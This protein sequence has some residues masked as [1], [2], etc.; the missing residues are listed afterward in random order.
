MED[1]VFGAVPTVT[2]YSGVNTTTITTP[3][4]QQMISHPSNTTRRD[5]SKDVDNFVRS[6]LHASTVHARALTSKKQ[7]ESEAQQVYQNLWAFQNSTSTS[8]GVC[9]CDNTIHFDYQNSQAVFNQQNY[10]VFTQRLQHLYALNFRVILPSLTDQTAYEVELARYVTSLASSNKDLT[11]VLDRLLDSLSHKGFLPSAHTINFLRELVTFTAITI[12]RSRS[13]DSE[14]EETPQSPS[15]SLISFNNPSSSSPSQ[16][17]IPG[18]ITASSLI[19]FPSVPTST[20]SSPPASTSSSSAKTTTLPLA[21]LLLYKILQTPSP[22]WST[23]LI[24]PLPHDLISHPFLS[25]L[26]PSADSPPASSYK[27]SESDYSS[28]LV[29]IP[30]SQLLCSQ[31]PPDYDFLKLNILTPLQRAINLCATSG[32]VPNASNSLPGTVTNASATASVPWVDTLILISKIITMIANVY[33]FEGNVLKCLAILTRTSWPSKLYTVPFLPLLAW[34]VLNPAGL[35]LG[36]AEIYN[37]TGTQ[38]NIQGYAGTNEKGKAE[39]RNRILSFMVQAASLIQSQTF[40]MLT[41][42]QKKTGFYPIFKCLS[43]IGACSKEFKLF[44]EELSF[45]AYIAAWGTNNPATQTARREAERE[46]VRI[47]LRSSDCIN[48]VIATLGNHLPAI[49]DIPFTL[50]SID[51]IIQRL[52]ENKLEWEISRA[53]LSWLGYFI[54]HRHPPT[55]SAEEDVDIWLN[56]WLGGRIGKQTGRVEFPQQAAVNGINVACKLVE[57]LI[58]KPDS[59]KDVPGWRWKLLLMLLGSKMIVG[60]EWLWKTLFKSKLCSDITRRE[61]EFVNEFI[62]R[63]IFDVSDYNDRHD[64]NLGAIEV[65]IVQVLFLLENLKTKKLKALASRSNNNNNNNDNNDTNEER[66][67]SSYLSGVDLKKYNVWNK[68]KFLVVSMNES[69]KGRPFPRDVV[70]QKILPIMFEL[71]MEEGEKYWREAYD[72]VT[73]YLFGSPTQQSSLSQRYGQMEGIKRDL[74]RLQREMRNL[75]FSSLSKSALTHDL[76]LAVK[77]WTKVLSHTSSDS[78]PTNA[79]GGTGIAGE[80]GRFSEDVLNEV[81]HGVW[82][83]Q[84]LNKDEVAPFQN[85]INIL[86]QQGVGDSR[87]INKAVNDGHVWISYVGT[88]INIQFGREAGNDGEIVKVCQ[89]L[90]MKTKDPILA[91]LFWDQFWQ[92]YFKTMTPNSSSGFGGNVMKN[93]LYEHFQRMAQRF[94]S[95]QKSQLTNVAPQ[96]MFY[97]LYYAF[98]TFSP[99]VI[100]GRGRIFDSMDL[101]QAFVAVCP[102]LWVPGAIN[103]ENANNNDSESFGTFHQRVDEETEERERREGRDEVLAMLIESISEPLPLPNYTQIKMGGT[104]LNQYE[105]LLQQNI[106]FLMNTNNS[107]MILPLLDKV[108][109]GLYQLASGKRMLVSSDEQFLSLARQLYKNAFTPFSVSVDCVSRGHRGMAAGGRQCFKPAVISGTK[110]GI[111]TGFPGIENE[112][113][114]NREAYNAQYLQIFTVGDNSEGG[115]TGLGGELA[116]WVVLLTDITYWLIRNR[117]NDIETGKKLFFFLFALILD[118]DNLTDVNAEGGFW[119]GVINCLLILGQTFVKNDPTAQYPILNTILSRL[120]SARRQSGDDPEASQANQKRIA[121]AAESWQVL[122]PIYE[123]FNPNIVFEAGDTNEASQQ[124]LMNEY[125]EMINII[126]F[127]STDLPASELSWLSERFNVDLFFARIQQLCEQNQ[128]EATTMQAMM[129]LTSQLLLHPALSVTLGTNFLL[130]LLTL[131]FPQWLGTVVSVLVHVTDTQKTPSRS[132]WEK[133]FF[134]KLTNLSQKNQG[135]LSFAM[136]W[137]KVLTSAV[138]VLRPGFFLLYLDIIKTQIL[139]SSEFMTELIQQAWGNSS[140]AQE[141]DE[142]EKPIRESPGTNLWSQGVELLLS[143]IVLSLLPSTVLPMNTVLEPVIVTLCD[144]VHQYPLLIDKIWYFYIQYLSK[145]FKKV[146]ND[147]NDNNQNLG[148]T[149]EQ[150]TALVNMISG[151]PWKHATFHI[152]DKSTTRELSKQMLMNRD[153]VYRIFD[154]LNWNSF[155]NLLND[156][157]SWVVPETNAFNKSEWSDTALYYL[158]LLFVVHIFK[159]HAPQGFFSSSYTSSSSSV[160]G[161]SAPTSSTSVT[162]LTTIDTMIDWSKIETGCFETIFDGTALIEPL[163]VRSFVLNQHSDPTLSLL[164]NAYMLRDV[165]LQINHPRAAVACVREVKSLCYFTL[166]QPLAPN[167]TVELG[168]FIPF[169][170]HLKLLTTIVIPISHQY[171]QHTAVASQFIMF[172]LS[173]LEDEWSKPVKIPVQIPWIT[174][175]PNVQV[176]PLPQ[177]LEDTTNQSLAAKIF[178]TSTK[179]DL[180]PFL[181][182][183]NGIVTQ[184]CASSS[185]EV[186]VEVLNISSSIIKEQSTLWMIYEVTLHSYFTQSTRTNPLSEATAAIAKPLNLSFGDTFELCIQLHTPLTFFVFIEQFKKSFDDLNNNWNRFLEFTVDYIIRFEPRGNREFE[187]LLLWFVVLDLI[188]D[189]RTRVNSEQIKTVVEKVLKYWQGFWKGEGK[190]GRVEKL[191]KVVTGVMSEWWSK[192]RI[193]VARNS[194]GRMQLGARSC[195]LQLGKIWRKKGGNSEVFVGIGGG[196]EDL[197]KEKEK[198]TGEEFKEFFEGLE[199]LESALM[200]VDDFKRTVL[201]RLVPIAPYLIRLTGGEAPGNSTS[202]NLDKKEKEEEEEVKKEETIKSDEEKLL[203]NL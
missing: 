98:T 58:L 27:L 38:A 78:T 157:S 155:I 189:N 124:T 92:S 112:I 100:A 49:Q 201:M 75:I 121:A 158:R 137:L 153:L 140:E 48:I 23:S 115:I 179:K 79:P 41:N 134:T 18:T 183:L 198:W 185:P 59:E 142:E 188:N 94:E 117:Q 123:L 162:N 171:A 103:E 52:N 178:S 195:A 26:F 16:T 127:G 200:G 25:L 159:P 176:P 108:Q 9:G 109:S 64:S 119:R 111:S 34:D 50:N 47:A 184:F 118:V 187:A 19:Q 172:I 37:L 199:E 60:D 61:E 181:T 141:G 145:H 67:H 138:P 191:E 106:S 174:P 74:Q 1:D 32:N 135:E 93:Q 143:K 66:T 42:Q 149:S 71:G 164:E 170:D 81:I 168:Y 152:V 4:A 130:R 113:T 72:L 43:I 17:S 62:T 63:D 54:T 163:K 45:Y 10:A 96:R 175:G 133:Q 154:R 22:S 193:Y 8:Q 57:H 21:S 51:F 30:W 91:L 120:E 69:E 88:L 3:S 11:S 147:A 7:L 126:A 99:E 40:N 107:Q 55:E 102:P 160:S 173:S 197:L 129:R 77:L 136:E 65:I 196:M 28:F 31:P 53:G 12:I 139:A 2:S 33:S 35:D 156:P 177:R 56:Y 5:P 104:D 194:T 180:K 167:S 97:S 131:N 87:R 128:M 144:L 83:Y 84:L 13:S 110:C 202:Q 166:K 44:I 132:G 116:K 169:D 86:A 101:S 203:D 151:L 73:V 85:I 125:I 148:F 68:V 122:K 76:S 186:A 29:Q 15:V 80:L 20:P 90:G 114:N 192:T 14:V 70:V 150:R 95:T 190:T 39:H 182:K 6:L 36:F 24:Q 161:A 46:L 146:P 82:C 89:T 165:T 105:Q